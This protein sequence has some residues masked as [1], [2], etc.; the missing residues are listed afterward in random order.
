MKHPDWPAIEAAYLDGDCT[1][2]QITV[3]YGISQDR[4]YKYARRHGWPPRRRHLPA[5]GLVLRGTANP[6]DVS[7]TM[8]ARLSRSLACHIDELEE[9]MKKPDRSTADKELETKRLT[10]L[11]QVLDRLMALAERLRAPALADTRSPEQ[12]KADYDRI[13]AAIAERVARLGNDRAADAL[14][15]KPHTG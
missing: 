2:A 12:V 9:A 7:I 4:L 6:D 15:A 3:R 11:T 10:A 5:K 14:L 8:L 13:V 1:V